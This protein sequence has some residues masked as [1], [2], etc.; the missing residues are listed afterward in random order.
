MDEVDSTPE[1]EEQTT[2]HTASPIAVAV[3]SQDVSTQLEQ[4]QIP[5]Q[6]GSG[7][8]RKIREENDRVEYE[9]FGGNISFSREENVR[10]EENMRAGV[11]PLTRFHGYFIS[12]TPQLV[13]PVDSSTALATITTRAE[14]KRQ[15]DTTMPPIQGFSRAPTT[16]PQTAGYRSPQQQQPRPKQVHQGQTTSTT[17]LTQKVSTASQTSTSR[18]QTAVPAI[19]PQVFSGVNAPTTVFSSTATAVAMAHLVSSSGKT[20]HTIQSALQNST[21]SK[22]AK[23]RPRKPGQRAMDD[24]D[25]SN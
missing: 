18:E 24:D 25:D 13:L 22:S 5:Q 15:R 21:K 16:Q 17:A 7:G 1:A 12:I 10:I 8:I 3:A 4:T 6:L 2:I 23:A 20:S 9:M 19:A 11:S 14:D